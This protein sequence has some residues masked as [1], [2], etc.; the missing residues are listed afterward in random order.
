MIVLTSHLSV[1]FPLSLR[2][3]I[4]IRSCALMDVTASSS[5]RNRCSSLTNCESEGEPEIVDKCEG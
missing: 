1:C 4:L 5:S 3:A 2:F